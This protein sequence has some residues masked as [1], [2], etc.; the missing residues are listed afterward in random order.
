LFIYLFSNECTSIAGIYELPLRVI[1]FE[2]G[3]DRNSIVEILARF[4]KAGKAHY[5]D[6]I[7]W[8]VNLRKYNET[9]SPK[10]RVR[11]E[12]DIASIPD[13]ELKRRYIQYH[14]G[15]DRVSIPEL[16][17]ESEHEHEHEIE[18]EKETEKEHDTTPQAA[19]GANAPLTSPPPQ[20]Q[21]RKP[22]GRNAVKAELE[23][24]FCEVTGIPP[25]ATRTAKQRKSAGS[26]WWNP[27]LEMAEWCQD[28]VD[29]SKRLVREAVL[30]LRRKDYTVSGPSSILKT[31]RAIFGEWSVNGRNDDGRQNSNRQPQRQTRKPALTDAERSAA[32]RLR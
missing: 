7:V 15:M 13:C 29:R 6:G 12:R 28:D 20:K 18:K 10:V 17:T 32:A 3:L 22:T 27:L 26:L 1:E 25:P 23:T 2:T 5:Q 11:I 24:F 9:S 4:S 21:K 8:V 30:R 19:Q 14:N 31:A 16:E